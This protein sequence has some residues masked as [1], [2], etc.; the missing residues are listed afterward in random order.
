[1]LL[2]Y[3][4]I[5]FSTTVS[6][7]PLTLVLTDVK[8]TSIVK[9]WR[10]CF[11]DGSS[12]RNATTDSRVCFNKPARRSTEKR[13]LISKQSSEQTSFSTKVTWLAHTFHVSAA[14]HVLSQ[15]WPS[16]GR[17]VEPHACCVKHFQCLKSKQFY[18]CEMPYYLGPLCTVPT[19]TDIEKIAWNEE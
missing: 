19:L 5:P 2:P 4:K 18:F 10:S 16:V 1:M 15:R 17:Q 12:F 7:M 9:F 13:N 11:V 8:L 14:L 6:S 3:F